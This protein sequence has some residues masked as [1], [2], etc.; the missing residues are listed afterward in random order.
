M[1]L[2]ELAN[3]L[4]GI[5]VRSNCDSVILPMES[6]ASTSDWT[7]AFSMKS[8]RMWGFYSMAANTGPVGFAALA[9]DN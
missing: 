2:I 9:S 3:L 6:A 5:K 1:P 8:D 7:L 4:V